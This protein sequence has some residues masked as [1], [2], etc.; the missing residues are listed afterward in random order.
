VTREFLYQRGW[1]VGAPGR[2]F[3]V[4][5]LKAAQPGKATPSSVPQVMLLR[6]VY[7]SDLNRKTETTPVILTE[8]KPGKY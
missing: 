1:L 4:G 2:V 5:L 3:A 6:G 7:Q 8:F